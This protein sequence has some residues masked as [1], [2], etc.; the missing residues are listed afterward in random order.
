M[1]ERIGPH[2][3]SV[4]ATLCPH[5]TDRAPGHPAGVYRVPAVYLAVHR[6]VRGGSGLSKTDFPAPAELAAPGK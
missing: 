5:C 4:Q 6:L 2:V 3:E 1:K